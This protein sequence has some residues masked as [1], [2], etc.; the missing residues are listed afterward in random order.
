M[1]SQQRTTALV[2][3]SITEK[4]PDAHPAISFSGLMQ[5]RQELMVVNLKII[6][7]QLK[8]DC[9]PKS[10]RSILLDTPCRTASILRYFLSLPSH[11]HTLILAE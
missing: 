4:V 5:I 8:N 9:P 10:K 2:A 1:V 3:T 11:M 7:S 6:K